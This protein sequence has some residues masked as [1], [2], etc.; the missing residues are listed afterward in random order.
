[1]YIQMFILLYYDLAHLPHI[2][3]PLFQFVCQL[4]QLLPKR[5]ALKKAIKQGI[6]SEKR[7]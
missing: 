2:L 5:K 1:M 4:E 7:A 3:N 6:A